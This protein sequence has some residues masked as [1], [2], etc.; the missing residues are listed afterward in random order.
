MSNGDHEAAT[1]THAANVSK[2]RN[3]VILTKRSEWPHCRMITSV[4]SAPRTPA[5]RAYDRQLWS[6]DLDRNDCV[7]RGRSTQSTCSHLIVS[8]YMLRKDPRVIDRYRDRL[9]DMGFCARFTFPAHASP[10][11][12]YDCV[13]R[14]L[15]FPSFFIVCIRNEN[16]PVRM[17]LVFL[18]CTLS[19]AILSLGIAIL[20]S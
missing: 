11:S 18:A 19:F 12:R 13:T 14:R 2:V 15:C 17:L 7:P 4:T 1:G 6:S 3:T 10:F 5:G 8:E 9:H 16:Q 20:I